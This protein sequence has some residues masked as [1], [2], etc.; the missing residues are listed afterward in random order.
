[1]Q[2]AL[3]PQEIK[4]NVLSGLTVALAMVPEA[5]AFA[6]VAQ[7]D[8]LVGLYTAFIIALVTSVFGGRPGMVSG[9][10]GAIAVV[11]VALVV[12][13]G[14]EYMF[15]AVVLMGLLQMAFGALKLGKFIR[16]VPHP[17]MLGF[18][19]GLAIVIFISQFEHF[20]VAGPGGTHAWMQGAELY[21]MLGLIALTMAVVYLLP[22]LTKAVPAT[23]VGIVGVSVLAIALGLETRTVGDLGSIAGGLPQ[24]HLPVVPF[25]LETLRIIA[26]YSLIMAAVGLIESLLTLNLIDTMTDTR[27]RPNRESLAQGLA[28]VVAGFFGGM[29]GCAMIGQSMI[30]VNAGALRRLSGIATALFL[31]SFIM[32]GS[33]LIEAVPMAALIGVMFVVAEKTFEWGSIQALRKV[34]RSDAIIVIAVTIV[35]V[36][37]DLA[38]AVGVGVIIAALVFAWKHAKHIKADAHVDD[39]GWKVYELDG[40]LF[41]A[42]CAGFQ[43][44][45]DPRNDP[46][47]VVVE[48]KR[49]R[50]VDH[51]ALD[52]IDAIA[53]RYAAAG[54]RLHLRHLTADC[55]ELLD[56][57]KGM[58]EV[59]VLE[60]PHYFIADDKVA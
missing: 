41:F 26:P 14:V 60:D 22:K 21:T 3:T 45:F 19:N 36:L 32:F 27:G 39:R 42:S 4:T 23:L 29:G 58:I 37:T 10:T 8:P 16:M 55:C 59:N 48:F 40:T 57:A 24:F 31:L 33:S 30:N 47:D 53:G 12:T 49:A 52:A 5:I 1:M 15:A 50:V 35:T 43:Q 34:P 51:S 11:I 9:A 28:N 6:I 38:I 46:D 25:N 18:V 2:L 17:V 13:H 56:K 7:V 54:K 44:L 20:Q